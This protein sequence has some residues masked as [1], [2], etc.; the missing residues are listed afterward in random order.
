MCTLD[1]K[2]LGKVILEIIESTQ[3]SFEVG[4]TFSKIT[5]RN[6]FQSQKGAHKLFF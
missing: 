6:I 4:L 1:W 5:F 2:I 3:L